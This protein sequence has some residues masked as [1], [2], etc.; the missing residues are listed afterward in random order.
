MKKQSESIR[1]KSSSELNKDVGLLRQE[2]AKLILESKVNPNKD[3]NFI[4]KKKKELALT[5]SVIAEKK[6]SES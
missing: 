1:T 2:I 5:L 3:T 6:L 4:Y